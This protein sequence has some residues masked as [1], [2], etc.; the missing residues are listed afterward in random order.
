MLKYGFIV[1]LVGVGM[2]FAILLGLS[3]M[4]DA[5]KLY[6]IR[7]MKKNKRY[8]SKKNKGIYSSS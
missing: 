3:F 8:Q 6:L 1:T 4:L 5:L 7:M 2:C